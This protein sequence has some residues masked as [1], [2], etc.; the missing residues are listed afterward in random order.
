[1]SG[2][3]KFSFI[4]SLPAIQSAIK[5]DGSGDGAR[6]TLDVPGSELESIIKMQILCGKAFRVTIEETDDKDIKESKGI[7][8]I[9]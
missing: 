5:I 4:A 3:L 2:N 6:I 9:K 7:K 1:M 8:F